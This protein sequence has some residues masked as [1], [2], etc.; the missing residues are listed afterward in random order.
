MKKI[1]LAFLAIITISQFSC[2][3]DCSCPPPIHQ[4]A[5]LYIGTYLTDNV[6]HPP[7]FCSFVLYPDST[8]IIK[9]KGNPPAADVV[10]STGNWSLNGNAVTYTSKTVVYSSEVHQT[11]SFTYDTNSGNLKDGKWQDISDDSGYF[12]TG[13]FPTMERVN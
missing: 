7:L 4:V 3:K 12:Y 9:A 1:L 10:L 6:S 8:L 13:T 2:K 11:G 5:G